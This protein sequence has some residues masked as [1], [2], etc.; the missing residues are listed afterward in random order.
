M[1]I[2]FGYEIVYQCP[3]P[4]PMILNLHAHYSRASDLLRP[5]Q[6]CID[7]PVAYG[8]SVETT[9]VLA[10]PAPLRSG[11]SY[12]LCLSGVDGRPATA[13]VSFTQ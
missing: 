8:D 12:Q 1:Q 11:N 6:L 4:T 5:D 13:C 2:R 3:Q 7:P 9:D 10:G